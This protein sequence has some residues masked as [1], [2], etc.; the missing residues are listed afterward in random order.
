[1]LIVTVF[2]CSCIYENVRT[3]GARILTYNIEAYTRK[4]L[5]QIYQITERM[6]S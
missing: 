2:H 5:I 1:M 3:A 4:G 6:N